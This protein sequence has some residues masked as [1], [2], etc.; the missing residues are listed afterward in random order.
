MGERGARLTPQVGTPQGETTHYILC[1][2]VLLQNVFA[3]HRLSAAGCVEGGDGPLGRRLWIAPLGA[4]LIKLSLR[5][6]LPALIV[7]LTPGEEFW[8]M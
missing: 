7:I 5:D 2:A 4:M 6:Y 8:Y 3:V 1:V